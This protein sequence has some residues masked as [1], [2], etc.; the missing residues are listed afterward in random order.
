MHPYDLR[1]KE[2]GTGKEGKGRRNLHGRQ[3]CL[4]Q[5][6]ILAFYWLVSGECGQYQHVYVL[7]LSCRRTRI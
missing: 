1:V 6:N 2:E 4:S 7:D 5:Q 3:D